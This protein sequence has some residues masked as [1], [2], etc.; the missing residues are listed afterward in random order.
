MTNKYIHTSKGANDECYTPRYAVEPLLEFMPKFKD[1]IIWC[2]F[3][4]EDS[5]FVKVLQE[6]NYNVVYSHIDYNQNFYNYEPEKWDL[7]I[8]NPPFTNKKQIFKRA[9]E[10]GKP[11]CLLNTILWLNDTAPTELFRNYDLQLLLFTQRM[12]FKN[13]LQDKQINFK[14]VYFCHDFLPK[15]III[16]DFNYGQ[17]NLFS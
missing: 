1:K 14:S 5:E 16:R 2:P 6:N 7:I 15:D 9:I 13:Q 8:S 11:F 10:F 4:K 17:Q 12:T 3:D